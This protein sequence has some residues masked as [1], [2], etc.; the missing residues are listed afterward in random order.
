MRGRC[1]FS[2][3]P[4]QLSFSLPLSFV[5]KHNCHSHNL[6]SSTL[7]RY[8]RQAKLPAAVV[9]P[10]GFR[11][12]RIQWHSTCL[13]ALSCVRRSWKCVH[14][15][16]SSFSLHKQITNRCEIVFCSQT[17]PRFNYDLRQFD[18][19]RLE[20]DAKKKCIS[21]KLNKNDQTKE[22]ADSWLIHPTAEPLKR[23]LNV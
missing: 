13:T 16:T 2:S 19:E 14:V 4:S 11:E 17:D 5:C 12:R 3:F 21:V 8:E 10:G 15:S 6:G 1:R 23:R 22:I 18:H 9:S 20:C 7:L